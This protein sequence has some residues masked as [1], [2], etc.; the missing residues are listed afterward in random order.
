MSKALLGLN[1][2]QNRYQEIVK[3]QDILH[4]SLEQV[5]VQVQVQVQ[6]FW[7]GKNR[8]TFYSMN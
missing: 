8:E 2:Y 7:K 4:L 6:E 1:R 5:P 3:E